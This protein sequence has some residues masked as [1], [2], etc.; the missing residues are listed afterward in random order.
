M[1]G[2]GD[3]KNLRGRKLLGGGSEFRGFQKVQSVCLL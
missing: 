2:A 3:L 1:G